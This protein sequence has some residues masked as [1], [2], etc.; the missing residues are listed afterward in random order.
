VDTLGFPLHG[1]DA[2]AVQQRAASDDLARRRAAKPV[3]A[4]FATTGALPGGDAALVKRMFRK[5][6]PHHLRPAA[7]TLVSGAADLRRREEA[8]GRSYASLQAASVADGDSA[9]VRQIEL[10]L[11]R[12]FP[13]HPWLRDSPSASDALRR[14]LLALAASQ[15]DGY[16]QSHNYLAAWLLLVYDTGKDE[17]AAFWTLRAMLEQ[18][19]APATFS[20]DLRGLHIELGTLQRLC[21]LKLPRVGRQ[22]TL[23]ECAPTLYATD[24]FLCLFIGVL[25]SDTALRV[26]DA[27]LQEGVKV[28][29]RVALALMRRAQAEV[30]RSDSLLA[31]VDAL[32]GEAKHAHDRDAL[33]ELACVGIGP[34]SGATVQRLRVLAEV[35]VARQHAES[36]ERRRKYD[37][38]HSHADE[39][40]P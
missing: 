21:Q 3:W 39:L 11:H 29:H 34:L 36:E 14:V 7:W 31:C 30:M 25:P 10:D 28:L 20:S 17:E 23:L 38:A 27:F 5:G 32:R 33:M 13:E 19:C 26:W 37:G 4:A 24:W 2:A 22:L 8:A 12:T 40:H 15:P 18:R 1:L 35:D 9:S 16:C 6:V